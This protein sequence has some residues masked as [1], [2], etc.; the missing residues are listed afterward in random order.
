MHTAPASLGVHTA[1]LTLHCTV[2]GWTLLFWSPRRYKFYAMRADSCR[3]RVCGV[4]YVSVCVDARCFQRMHTLLRLMCGVRHVR[5]VRGAER[6]RARQSSAS[7][8]C[9]QCVVCVHLSTYPLTYMAQ[10]MASIICHIAIY[11]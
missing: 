8:K 3:R 10:S 9:H 2:Y 11:A 7:A 6:C 4:V 1:L 5:A